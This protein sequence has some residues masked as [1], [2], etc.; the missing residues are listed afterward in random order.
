MIALV[1]SFITI[2]LQMKKHWVMLLQMKSLSLAVKTVLL[3]LEK[4]TLYYV[5]IPSNLLG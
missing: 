5:R 3:Q 2:I 4:I 1:E